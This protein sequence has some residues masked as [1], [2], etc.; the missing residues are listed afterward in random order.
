MFYLF[1]PLN[2]KN[3]LATGKNLEPLT[4]QNTAYLLNNYILSPGAMPVILCLASH[5]NSRLFSTP[6][7]GKQPLLTHL[8]IP[9]TIQFSTL[10]IIDGF[11]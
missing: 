11:A 4:Q 2:I 6:L 9:C 10:C 8:C 1:A 3:R 7:E 5:S